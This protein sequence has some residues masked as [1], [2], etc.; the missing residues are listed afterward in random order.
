MDALLVAGECCWTYVGL[1]GQAAIRYFNTERSGIMLQRS[2]SLV[3]ICAACVSCG[4]GSTPA[5]ESQRAAQT[6]PDDE[7]ITVTPSTNLTDGQYVHV[8]LKTSAYAVA[9]C[10][11]DATTLY[12]CF[13]GEVTSWQPDGTLTARLPVHRAFVSQGRYV[14]CEQPGACM[15]AFEVGAALV[16]TP[17]HFRTQGPWPAGGSLE[18]SPASNLIDRQQVTVSGSGFS[19]NYEIYLAQCRPSAGAPYSN[20]GNAWPV[21]LNDDGTFSQDFEVKRTY[22][23]DPEGQG[24]SFTC[25]TPG[26]CV[27][28][29]GP[30]IPPGGTGLWG[31]TSPLSFAPV[32]S[33][34]P[35]TL[36][37]PAT[38]TADSNF[39]LSG[40]GWAESSTLVVRLCATAADGREFC[41][42]AMD[43]L[44]LERGATTFSTTIQAPGLMMWW[45]S[46]LGLADCTAAPGTCRVVVEDIADPVNARVSVPL[47]I[48][49]PPVPRGTAALDLHSPLVPDMRA[50]VVGEGWRPEAN[51]EFLWCKGTDLEDCIPRGYMST[52][53]AG[54][55]RWYPELTGKFTFRPDFDCTT[56]PETCSLVIA[57]HLAFTATAVRIPL[58]FHTGA[59]VD[60]ISRYEAKWH[61]LLEEGTSISGL[62][63]TELQRR[64]PAVLLWLL[65]MGNE[66]SATQLPTAGT[67]AVSTS[68][69]ADA[70]RALSEVALRYDYTVVELQKIST[71][72]YA[73]ALAGTPPLPP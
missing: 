23:A 49:S 60:V 58:T 13:S 21:T 59:Q 7:L 36:Q 28:Y 45:V 5:S 47:T 62:S 53:A 56:A 40:S 64:A 24:E 4:E 73:W 31:S 33:P 37:V 63:L 55:F 15:V 71:V 69:D 22:F 39:E 51:L 3:F 54:R 11:S 44:Q 16:G 32:G 48:Q 50:R 70:Y 42:L 29:A 12:Y 19:P 34:R 35:G 9:L 41:N 68:Y 6:A 18:V 8:V 61:P 65:R 26:A 43:R 25:D 67:L 66:G 14:D 2:V 17:I 46:P 38:I 20:C 30:Q 27:L 72:F 52:D 57:D 10:P 1:S